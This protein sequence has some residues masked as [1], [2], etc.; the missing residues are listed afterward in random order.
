MVNEVELMK[1]ISQICKA[2]NLGNIH[3]CKRQNLGFNRVV[4]IIND[5][6]VIKI[7]INHD[8]ETGIKNEIQ[9]YEKN[10]NYFNPKLI[11]YDLTKKIIPYIYTVEEKIDG[12][13][14]F[15]IWEN[16]DKKSREN[17]LLELVKI[18]R[19]LHKPIK[20]EDANVDYVIV[21]YNT[22]L[23]KIKKSNI[24]PTKKIEYLNLLKIIIP[25]YFN[26][27]KFGYIH[28]DIHFNNLIYCSDGLK[29]IDFECYDKGPLDKDFDS[30]NRMVRNPNSL[31][32][33]GLQSFVNPD[34]YTTIMPFL[35]QHYQ[36][37]CGN[38]NFDNR[39]LI[40][41]CINSLKW[42]SVY[43]NYEP[44]HDILFNKSRKLIK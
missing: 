34:D 28:G 9:Y 29:L 32:K 43:P 35:K 2:N 25:S 42:L 17:C 8:K 30:I 39:L 10:Q 20:V 16:L 38:I 41:D 36:E 26:D 40:Y 12:D 3:S 4:C 15:N 19:T 21:K 14:L 37:I 6:Y 27:A 33:K 44:Y 23:E 5:T 11:T 13:N 18:L 1:F 31:I 24:L 22:Y 7:C